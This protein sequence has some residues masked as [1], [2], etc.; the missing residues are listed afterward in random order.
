MAMSHNMP[1]PLFLT[2]E[3][4]VTDIVKSG[5]A[6]TTA[7]GAVGVACPDGTDAV[8]ASMQKQKMSVAALSDL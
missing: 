5:E 7:G 2:E 1:V 8:N 4:G 3:V 6:A